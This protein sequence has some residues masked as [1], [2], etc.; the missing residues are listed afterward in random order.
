VIKPHFFASYRTERD[1]L[2]HLDTAAGYLAKKAVAAS[3]RLSERS[4]DEATEDAPW[5]GVPT[6][7][8]LATELVPMMV[9]IQSLTRSEDATLHQ[10]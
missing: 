8:T 7:I 1:N 9:K 4:L 5:G 10:H 6:K 2:G 3:T